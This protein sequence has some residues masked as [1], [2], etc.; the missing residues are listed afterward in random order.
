MGLTKFP[1]FNDEE[2]HYHYLVRYSQNCIFEKIAIET[3]P[4]PSA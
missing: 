4:E 1:E 2:E 3:P